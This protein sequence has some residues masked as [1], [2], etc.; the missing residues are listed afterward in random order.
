VIFYSTVRADREVTAAGEAPNRPWGDWTPQRYLVDRQIQIVPHNR[1][2]R[3]RQRTAV[4]E[5]RVQGGLVAGG[6]GLTE[7]GRPQAP[8]FGDRQLRL[9]RCEAALK[10][11]LGVLDWYIA[12]V[13]AA[14]SPNRASPG[15]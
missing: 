2:P 6:V 12:E 13:K 4:F 9:R 11:F 3:D 14:Y 8:L 10:A 5:M 7:S 15:A 1:W